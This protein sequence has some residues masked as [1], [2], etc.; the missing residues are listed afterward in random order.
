MNEA[1]RGEWIAFAK[2]TLRSP[3]RTGRRGGTFEHT[4][5]FPRITVGF[6]VINLDD[7]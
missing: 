1:D 6:E 2:M 5:N 7:A 4:L 3:S